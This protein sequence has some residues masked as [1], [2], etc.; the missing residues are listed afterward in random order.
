MD[1]S[2]NNIPVLNDDDLIHYLYTDPAINLNNLFCKQSTNLLKFNKNCDKFGFSPLNITTFECVNKIKDEEF[3]KNILV[4]DEYK[5]INIEKVILDKCTTIDELER[6]KKEIKLFKEYNLL[7]I[8]KFI[9]FLVDKMREN[10]IVWGVGRGSSV[11]SFVLYLIGLNKINPMRYH[12]EYTEFFRK[13]NN[14]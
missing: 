14:E 3:Y 2:L 5:N 1:F 10:K 4:P 8:L 7:N 9:I 6:A 12:I 11:A 13:E